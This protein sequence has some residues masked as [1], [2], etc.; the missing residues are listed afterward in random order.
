MSRLNKENTVLKY[1]RHLKNLPNTLPP[2]YTVLRP[3]FPKAVVNTKEYI[4]RVIDAPVQSKPFNDIFKKDSK[5]LIILSDITRYTAN[6]RYLPIIIDRLN[7]TGIDDKN[8]TLICALG[9]HKKQ[10]AHEHKKLIGSHLYERFE[11]LDHDAFDKKNMVFL[12][13]TRRGTPIEINHLLTETDHIILTGS[14]SFHYFAGFGGGRKSILPG[15]SSL[16]S[17]VANHLLVLNPQNQ[18]GRHPLAR[19]SI[20]KGNPVHED[21]SEACDYFKSLFLFNTILSPQRELLKVVAGDVHAAFNQGC[22]FL[23]NNF[24]V[25]ITKKADLIIASCGGHPWDINFIQAHKTL[26]MATNVLK[27][28]GVMILLA[29]CSQ[30]SGNPRFLK[31]FN[32]E[33]AESFE[34]NLRTDYEINGQTAYATFLKAKKHHIILLSSLKDLEVKKMSLIPASTIEEALENAYNLLGSSP[35]TY[36]IPDGNCILPSLIP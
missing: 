18:S 11:V 9:I 15:V 10:T 12:G 16:N 6:E 25:P 19:T 29:E 30:G 36:I 4:N 7:H 13:T 28:G 31:W 34:S 5:V 26:E 8:I 32:N 27:K 35:L 23:K 17:C 33:S 21:M 2:S 14:I 24:S 22:R 3:S 20:L 1:G